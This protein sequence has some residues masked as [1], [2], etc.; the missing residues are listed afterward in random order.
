MHGAHPMVL[1]RLPLVVHM[2]MVRYLVAVRTMLSNIMAVMLY[3]CVLHQEGTCQCQ[4]NPLKR[5]TWGVQ[6]R[7]HRVPPCCVP[8]KTC[9]VADGRTTTS[10]V[11]TMA[12]LHAS[13]LL[14]VWFSVGSE[15]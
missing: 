8:S 9:F 7:G 10:S 11:G 12:S 4:D 5:A 2:V 14:I 13:A 15:H 6:W 3:R 1:Y